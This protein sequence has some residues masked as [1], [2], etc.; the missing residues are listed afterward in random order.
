MRDDLAPWILTSAI[1]SADV[2]SVMARL[3]RTNRRSGKKF[4]PEIARSLLMDEMPHGG[5]RA[6]A[7]LEAWQYP[8]P[9]R[10]ENV[11]LASGIVQRWCVVG[12]RFDR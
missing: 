4:P 5:V 8:T 11:V 9:R 7:Q 1:R 3:T 2:N 12:P 10:L 6:A